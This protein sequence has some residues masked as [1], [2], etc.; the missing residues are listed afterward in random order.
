DVRAAPESS[1][2]QVWEGTALNAPVLENEFLRVE[3]DESRSCIASIRDLAGD[4]ELVN[5][6]SVFGFDQYV[7]DEY[8]TASGYNH[9]SNRSSSSSK[10]ELLGRRNLAGPSVLTDAIDDGVE[11]RLV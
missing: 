6:D 3:Y 1:T 10:L 8:T 5:A 7:Y 4:R 2:A 11:Q 9:H